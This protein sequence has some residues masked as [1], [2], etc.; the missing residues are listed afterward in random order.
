MDEGRNERPDGKK[1]QR[2]EG[3]PRKRGEEKGRALSHP[4]HHGRWSEIVDG[5]WKHVQGLVPP[6]FAHSLLIVLARY[7]APKP[8]S[9]FTTATPAE[10]VL[11]MARRADTPWKLAP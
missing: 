8:L 9:I 6:A 1:R 11:S 7:P 2:L 10:Q 5:L 4:I 3:K